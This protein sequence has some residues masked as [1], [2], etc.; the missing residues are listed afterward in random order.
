MARGALSR[1]SIRDRSRESSGPLDPASGSASGPRARGTGHLTVADI[2]SAAVP[3]ATTPEIGWR[4]W[5][6]EWGSHEYVGE[7][8][9]EA[10]VDFAPEGRAHLR[11]QIFRPALVLV[12]GWRTAWPK[13]RELVAR[14]ALHRCHFAPDPGCTCGIYAVRRWHNC[15]MRGSHYPEGWSESHVVQRVFGE[16]SLWGRVVPGTRGWRAAYAYPRRIF[17]PR[18]RYARGPQVSTEEIAFHLAD[19]GVPVEILETS[20]PDADA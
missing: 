18:V 12:S 5:R 3:D 10:Q 7:I 1:V 2:L 15:L 11:H 9:E 6:V 20:T 19:Y 17:V 8:V 13:R 4:F 14:C 16:V